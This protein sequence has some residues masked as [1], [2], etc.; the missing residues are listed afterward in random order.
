MDDL[1]NELESVQ[2]LVFDGLS[3]ED[4]ELLGH[5]YGLYF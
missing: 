1:E 4:D 5:L 2:E 3:G